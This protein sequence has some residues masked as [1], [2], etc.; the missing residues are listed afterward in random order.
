MF[1]DFTVVVS[2]DVKTFFNNN[3]FTPEYDKLKNR[4]A[5]VTKSS[6]YCMVGDNK[7]T[8]RSF[9]EYPN[10]LQQNKYRNK[11]IEAC[12]IIIKN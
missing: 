4:I 9:F 8:V 6:V 10:N 2:R 12:K 11:I 5:E 7:I 3:K 1:K